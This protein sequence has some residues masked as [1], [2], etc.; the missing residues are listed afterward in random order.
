[1][2]RVAALVLVLV[3]ATAVLYVSRFWPV[4]LWSRQS[5]LGQLGLRPRGGLLQVWLRG[6]PFAQFELLIWVVGG[7]IALSLT[8]R[9]VAWVKPAE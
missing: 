5:V 4:E 2:R 8:E 3:V 7:F 6:T 9:L 1:M